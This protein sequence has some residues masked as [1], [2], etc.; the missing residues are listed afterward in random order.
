MTSGLLSDRQFDRAAREREQVSLANE[1]AS[2]RV[3]RLEGEL[4]EL[5]RAKEGL[6]NSSV[7]RL[8]DEI[9]DYTNGTVSAGGVTVLS[10]IVAAAGLW[11]NPIR[12]TSPAKGI[13]IAKRFFSEAGVPDGRII[14]V[15]E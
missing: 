11:K 5:K 6:E 9:F 14:I 2:S 7:L 8:S 10:K 4:A 13:N 3:R 15:S 12:V 1:A